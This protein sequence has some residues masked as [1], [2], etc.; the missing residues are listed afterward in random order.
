MLILK[1]AWR[2]MIRHRRRSI[3]TGGAIALSLAMMLVFVGLADDGHDRMAELGIRMG[4]G[5]VLVQGA[6]YQASRTLE[7]RIADP[8]RVL[9]AARSVPRV[10]HAVP[11]VR[12]TGLLSTG[13]SSAPVLASGV[14]PALEVKASDLPDP[15]RRRQGAYLRSRGQMPFENQP[16]DIYIGEELARTLDLQVGDRTVLIVSPLSGSRPVSAAYL[17]RGIYRTGVNEVDQMWVEVPIAEL[18]RQLGLGD[19]VTQVAVLVDQLSDTAGVATALT[20][21]LVGRGLEASLPTGAK[22]V[23]G[24]EVLPWQVALSELHEAIVLDDAGMYLMMFIIFL[25]VTIGIFNTVLMSVVERTREFGMMMAIGTGRAQ[26]FGVMFTEALLLSLLSAAV[27]LGIGLGLHALIASH[28]IDIASMAEDYQIAG[29]VMEGRIY[30]RLSVEVV[31]KWTVV[32][33]GLTLLSAVYPALRAT[34][35]QPVEAI[36]HV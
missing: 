35:L 32:V 10:R 25:I 9:A 6:G 29:I 13:D 21:K 17:V 26:L 33:I 16:A 28:G 23:G 20:E 12:V 11:R 24:L 34:R 1:L 3:I 31:L 30:S 15:R 18:Q 4:A 5:H 8:G 7:H 14:D 2:S 27:G 22:P 36:R 19:Q